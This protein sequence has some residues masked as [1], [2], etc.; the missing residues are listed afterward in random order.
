MT[1]LLAKNV[2]NF[3][4]LK[5]ERLWVQKYSLKPTRQL[6]LREIVR[7]FAFV[8]S[9]A[10]VKLLDAGCGTG[11]LAADIQNILSPADFHVT[12][13]DISSEMLKIAA[14]KQLPRTR[15]MLGDVSKLPFTNE[16]FDLVTCCHSF[17]YYPDQAQALRE[18]LR[19]LKPGG[20]L[21][22][23]N[24]SENNSYDRLV[25]KL[26]KLTTGPAAYPSGAELTA[27]VKSTGARLLEQKRLKT[28]IFV[29]SIILNII[30]VGQQHENSPDQAKTT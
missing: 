9:H 17:P 8:D 21:L 11:Q 22:L 16:Q 20:R 27:L 6:I 26:V 29:P 28:A 2:W 7:S 1:L 23:I 19:V 13:I 3:W 4:A 12:G 15:F 18:L 30:G 25:M 14:G 10:P 24:A 5:Y